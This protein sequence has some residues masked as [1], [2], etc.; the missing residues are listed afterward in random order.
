MQRED[1]TRSSKATTTS[2]DSGA[3]STITCPS[4]ENNVDE[5]YLHFPDPGH[6]RFTP[7]PSKKHKQRKLCDDLLRAKKRID[8][9]KRLEQMTMVYMENIEKMLEVKDVLP[10]L[11]HVIGKLNTSNNPFPF[12]FSIPVQLENK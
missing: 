9:E 5:D 6:H 1:E 10:H 2:G 11:R 7:L 12:T 3:G 8:G 4:D